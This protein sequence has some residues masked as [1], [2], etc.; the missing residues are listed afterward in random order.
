MT[1]PSD[2]VNHDT[3]LDAF[4]LLCGDLIGS[5]SE[6]EVFECRLRPDLVVKV[7]IEKK[8]RTFSNAREMELWCDSKG[9]E[10]IR[11][12]LAPCEYMS[13]D[14]RILLMKRAAP[15]TDKKQLLDKLPYFLW[16]L[17]PENFGIY[18]DRLVCVDYAYFNYNTRT[19]MVN[20]KWNDTEK[21][22]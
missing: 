2:N 12:W 11:R 16:D 8:W 7:E 21:L 5:G 3:F 20:A 17:K 1:S 10:K 18:E 22:L 9:D 14:G 19:N 6:R 4:N 15:I 13:P